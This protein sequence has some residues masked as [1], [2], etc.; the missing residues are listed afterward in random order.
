MRTGGGT[1]K[2]LTL[3]RVGFNAKPWRVSARQHRMTAGNRVHIERKGKEKMSNSAL[4]KESVK[5][6]TLKGNPTVFNG[7][8][9]HALTMD[10]YEEWQSDKSVILARQSTLPVTFVTMPFIDALFALDLAAFEETHK[11]AGTMN[12]VLHAMAL[13]LRMPENSVGTR[14]IGLVTNHMELKGFYVNQADGT[15]QFIPKEDFPQIRKI[16]AWQQGED[17]PDESL[18]DELLEDEK[19]IAQRNAGNLEIDMDSLLASVALNAHMRIRDVYGMSILEFEVTR[20]AIDRDKKYMICAAAESAGT[21][22]KGGNPH[23]SW[24]FDRKKAESAT[25]THVSKFEGI[26]QR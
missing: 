7:L 13:A 8:A 25:L 1:V 11:L 24:C 20:S 17:I 16:L 3:F 19:W 6:E 26:A 15:Q 10:R 2:A 22:W 5:R 14:Q 23:P 4:T 21:K 12:R 9:F 18:N